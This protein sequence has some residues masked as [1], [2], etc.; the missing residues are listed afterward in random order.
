MLIGAI[1]GLVGQSGTYPFEI[2][3][4]RMQTV[5]LVS[6]SSAESVLHTKDLS[7]VKAPPTLFETVHRLYLEEGLR[8]FFKG[9]SMNWIKGPVA[10][11]ISFTSYDKIK[12]AMID[13]KTARI[14]LEEECAKP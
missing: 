10:F 9:L 7:L 2:T 3:R 1:A 14:L 13:A 8:G 5:G 6:G 12:G 11:S 4:R